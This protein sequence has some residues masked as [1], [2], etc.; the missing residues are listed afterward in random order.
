MNNS[1]FHLKVKVIW[2]NKFLGIAVDQVKTKQRWCYFLTPYYFWPK[3]EAWSQ[4]KLELD[5]KLWLTEKEKIEILQLAGDVM[6]YWLLYRKIK[7]ADDLKK[8]FQEVE[9]VRF[10]EKFLN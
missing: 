2:S 1:K 3:T 6:N 8:D 7:T 10:P 4:L 9:I 5:S